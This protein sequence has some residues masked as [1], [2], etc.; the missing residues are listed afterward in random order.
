[1]EK[2]EKTIADKLHMDFKKLL[3][4]SILL[5]ILFLIF[6]IIIYMNPYITASTTVII[7]GIYFIMFG[8]FAIFEFLLRKTNPI[9]KYK[10]FSGILVIIVGIFMMINPFKIAKILTFALGIYLIIIS[11]VKVVEAFKLKKYGYDGWL[12]MLVT[13]ILILIFGVFITINPMAAIDIVK[14][15]GIFIIL[16]SLLEVC[17]LVMVYSKAKEIVKLFNA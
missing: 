8:V 12:L 7:T 9:F 4:G 3:L 14:A 2:K 10:V 17:N 15:A 6:G 16:S 11:L 13:A 1:M 5:N